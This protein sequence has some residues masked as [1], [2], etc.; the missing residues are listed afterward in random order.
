MKRI[1]LFMLSVFLVFPLF[2]QIVD[3][4]PTNSS[5]D[6][7]TIVVE[8]QI[9]DTTAEMTYDVII[10][11][12]GEFHNITDVNYDR[13]CIDVGKENHKPIYDTNKFDIRWQPI[14]ETFTLFKDR[15]DIQTF[16]FSSITKYNNQ[17]KI[18]PKFELVTDVGLILLC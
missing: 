17:T 6:H 14:T 3:H 18:I 4:E 8:M 16:I 7:A 10:G 5:E 15:Y 9:V 2:A 1:I 11:D 13:V 12:Y